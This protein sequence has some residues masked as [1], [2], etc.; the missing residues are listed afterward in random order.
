[1]WRPWVR[2]CTF[3]SPPPHTRTLLR[4]RYLQL[5]QH[6]DDFAVQRVL[7][8]PPR[9]IGAVSQER[10]RQWAVANDCSLWEACAAVAIADANVSSH[11]HSS[12]ANARSEEED[13]DPVFQPAPVLRGRAK[14]GVVSFFETVQALR[15]KARELEEAGRLVVS[16]C[17]RCSSVVVISGCLPDR[18]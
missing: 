9:G 5:L 16:A 13:H 11:S 4:G 7:N 3:V 14:H 6:D 12:H 15:E 10:M 1:M 2:A 17:V 8:V 18:V